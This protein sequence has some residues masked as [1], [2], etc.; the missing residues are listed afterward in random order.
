MPR[1]PG[2][3][4]LMMW[5][6]A[7]VG[8]LLALLTLSSTA[9]A[10]TA[11]G[12]ITGTIKDATGAV[13]PGASV[14]VHSDLTGLNRTAVSNQNGDYSFPLLPVGTYWVGVELQSFRP[15]K[16]TGI[17]LNVDQVLRIDLDL[18]LGGV[19]EVVEVQAATVAIDSE[20]ASV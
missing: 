12:Q 16:R 11:T 5:K 18:A 2:S 13:V 19:T 3:E 17:R 15:A 20:S 8:T 1:E 10:Q 9:R 6:K 14:T 4:G 7:L